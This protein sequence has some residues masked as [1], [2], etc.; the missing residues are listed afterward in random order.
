M[1]VVGGLGGVAAVDNDRICVQRALRPNTSSLLHPE[2]ISVPPHPQ[3]Q[4]GDR[5][6]RLH[7]FA[8]PWYGTVCRRLHWGATRLLAYHFSI[9]RPRERT[10][11]GSGDVAMSRALIGSQL[12]CQRVRATATLPGLSGKTAR[13]TKNAL[14]GGK[15]RHFGC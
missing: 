1:V 6:R 11:V 9:E 8:S 14:S 5:N 13:Q 4:R 3:R 7:W 15:T 2:L 12:F 10:R